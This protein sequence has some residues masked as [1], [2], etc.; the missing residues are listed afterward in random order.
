MITDCFG[1]S[2]YYGLEERGFIFD[3][4]V[5]MIAVVPA[6]IGYALWRIFVTNRTGPEGTTILGLD[7]N[8]ATYTE[9][10]D[11]G[12]SW[13]RLLVYGLTGCLFAFEAFV[14]LMD[15]LSVGVSD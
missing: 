11:H 6:A 8:S 12:I 4:G 9:V 1:G 15:L 3:V 5:L 2:Y 7:E 10:Y 13:Q 14:N